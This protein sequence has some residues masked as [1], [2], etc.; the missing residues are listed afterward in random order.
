L[1]NGTYSRELKT[2]VGTITLH[3]CRDREGNFKTELFDKYQRSEKALVLGIIEMY[4]EGVSTRNVG[5]VFEELCGF[6]VSK[7]QVSNLATKLDA[8]LNDWRMRRL[9]AIYLYIILDA[10]Y[11]KVRENGRI[12]S[13]AFV[14]AIGI[15]ADGK[16]EIIGCWVIN[17][18]SF[19]AWDH[20]LAELKNRGLNDI[21]YVV[22]DENKGLKLAI[23]KR[24]QGAQWQRCQVHFMRNLMGKIAQSEKATCVTLL[25][26]LF[27]APS[28]DVA[29]ERLKPLTDFLRKQKKEAVAQWLESDI[30]DTLAVYDLPQE[31]RKKMRSTNMLE[32]FN[33]E[34]KRRSK[35]V[36]I[37]PNEQSCLRLLTA[38]CLETSESWEDRRYLAM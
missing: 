35:V 7:S 1:R 11:E 32:R 12:I 38:I 9:T 16:R 3:V 2:R 34:L 13:K 28:K 24:F 27:N 8:D 25:Q 14:T 21:Q 37:F 22:S 15:A 20:C 10:R 26:D 36:R 33:E 29:L 18:E 30:E 31:H 23:Q 5:K 4:I 19:E 6:D 17:S